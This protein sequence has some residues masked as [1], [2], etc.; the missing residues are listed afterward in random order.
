MFQPAIIDC[1]T[2]HHATTLRQLLESLGYPAVAATAVHK[3]DTGHLVAAIGP[4]TTVE[5]LWEP[6]LVLS[7]HESGRSTVAAILTKG[8]HESVNA[9]PA[10]LRNAL[11]NTLV[12]AVTQS[13]DSISAIEPPG[14]GVNP[15]GGAEDGTPEF[16]DDD[17]VTTAP[18]KNPAGGGHETRCPPDS[19]Y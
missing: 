12:S 6:A 16:I 11:R 17:A 8:G 2:F 5:A 10:A 19:L 1:V 14:T 15:D 3:G 4:D 7:M 18:V 9:V 13:A